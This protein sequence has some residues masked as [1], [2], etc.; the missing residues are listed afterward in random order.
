MS[1]VKVRKNNVGR[2]IVRFLI[3]AIII[4]AVVIVLNEVVLKKPDTPILAE[5]TPR[6]TSELVVPT[7]QPEP[8]T[9]Q[10]ENPG[11]DTGLP[12]ENPQPGQLPGTVEGQTG[13]FGETNTGNEEPIINEFGSEPTPTPEATVEETPEPVVTP[14]PIP[15]PGEPTPTPVPASLYAQLNAAAKNEK[16]KLDKAT[17][18][19]N[20][21]TSWVTGTSENGGSVISLV[22]WSIGN[23][24]GFNAKTNNTCYVYVTNEK[25]DR[26][27]YT[28][29]KAQGATG[30]KHT[31]RNGHNLDYADFTCVI[32]LT[33]YPNGTYSLGTANYFIIEMSGKRNKYHFGYTLGDA[34]VFTVV[35]GVLTSVGGKETN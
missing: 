5:A 1:A 2:A 30:I 11:D 28:A 25:G 32:D 34:Y 21:I 14:D 13:E 19:K 12:A 9:L 7:D 29:T 33:N 35:D 31:L 26:Q 8:E 22:G 24:E 15:T 27:F 16:W 10:S 23:Q 3:G 17:R 4:A 6:P 20:G 18:I